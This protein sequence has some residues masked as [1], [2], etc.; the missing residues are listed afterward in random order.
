MEINT[1]FV[2]IIPYKKMRLP[3]KEDGGK[4]DII[5]IAKLH[6]IVYIF[7]CKY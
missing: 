1:I 4:A 3:V 5:L 2:I 7:S 6:G